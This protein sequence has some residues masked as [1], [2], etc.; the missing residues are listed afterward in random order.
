MRKKIRLIAENNDRNEQIVKDALQALSEGRHILLLSERIK[1]LNELYAKLKQ[2]T[3]KSIFDYW[4][5]KI[6]H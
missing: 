2:K 1:H 6:I 4:N 3:S 5:T